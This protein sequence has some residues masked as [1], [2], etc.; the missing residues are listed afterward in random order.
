MVAEED[1]E[2]EDENDVQVL[3]GEEEVN[4][5][6]LSDTPRGRY[7]RLL[8]LGKQIAQKGSVASERFGN[9]VTKLTGV[10]ESLTEPQHEEIR[11]ADGHRRG[12]PRGTSHTHFRRE[13][14]PCPLCD[15]AHDMQKCK[16]YRVFLEQKT[17]YQ[18]A[19]KGKIHCK[20]CGYAGHRRNACPVLAAFR[21][22]VAEQGSVSR[23][24]RGT[25]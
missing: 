7:L 24:K 20:L 6:V 12:R 16:M 18:G 10:L 4:S 1:G 22:Q 9:I 2:E 8:Y 13:V 14:G 23:R 3:D 17:R 5:L 19:S 25:R 21:R 11:D 15:G